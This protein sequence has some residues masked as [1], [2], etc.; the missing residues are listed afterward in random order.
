MKPENRAEGLFT[1]APLR[2]TVMY[3]GMAGYKVSVP[4]IDTLEVVDAAS[5]DALASRVEELEAALKYYANVDNLQDFAH[6]VS[7][8]CS[9]DDRIYGE[10][11]SR[12]CDK[13]KAA[14]EGKADG[15]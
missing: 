11:D 9:L 15:K 2:F 8:P 4:N 12:I 3:R 7:D 1:V 6:A 14:L 13:A 5:Y 10:L